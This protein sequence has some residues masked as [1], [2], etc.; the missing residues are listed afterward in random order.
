MKF[1]KLVLPIVAFLS[2]CGLAGCVTPDGGGNP[3]GDS[4]PGPVNSNGDTSSTPA[5]PLPEGW[6][7]TI[8]IYYRNDTA[9]Y[10][11]LCLWV[12]ATGIEGSIYRFTNEGNPDEYGLYCDIDLKAAPFNRLELT[13]I[14]FIVRN[15]TNWDGQS[16]DVIINFNDYSGT[17]ETVDGRE[18]ITV[19]S[20]GLTNNNVMVSSNRMD[21][22]GDRIGS[23]YFED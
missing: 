19:Y 10:N 2:V 4:T 18:R 21:A 15:K 20:W 13:G 9:S 6:Q 8:R 12:W 23:M 22:L 16:Q 5:V 1:P 14:S 7:D 17:L 11:N 3:V